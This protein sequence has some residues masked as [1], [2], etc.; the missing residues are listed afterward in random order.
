MSTTFDSWLDEPRAADPPRRV[1]RDWFVV[2]AAWISVALEVLLRDDIAAPFTAV[3]LTALL[4]VALLWRRTHPL[5]VLL[6]MFVAVTIHDVIVVLA[7]SEPLNLYA[8]A[9]LVVALYSLFR[10]GSGREMVIGTPVVIVFAVVVNALAYTGVGDFVGGF[11]VLALVVAVALVVRYR[12]RILEQGRQQAK[13]EERERLARDLHDTV[14]HHVSAIAI[15][16]QAGRFVADNGSLSG[17]V[18]ALEIIEEE[19]SRTLHEMRSIVEVL[20][21]ENTAVPLTPLHGLADIASLGSTTGSPTVTVTV[22][23]DADQGVSEAVGA[24]AYRIA[25][26]SITNARRHARDA[27]LVD[28]RVHVDAATVRVDVT[29]DGIPGSVHPHGFGL[30]GMTERVDLLG[31]TLDAGPLPGRGWAVRACLP[32]QNAS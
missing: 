12:R 26:E 3:P 1:W 11:V 15:Q 17:A 29:D 13:I 14:A 24:A 2:A 23:V 31:G 10:W 4:A 5:A 16:A 9:V 21:D 7:G 25:Q 18:D 6:A 27:S 28:V 32:R 22:T 30:I 19:A 8:S 20:R